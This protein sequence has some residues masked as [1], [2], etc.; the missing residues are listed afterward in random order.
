MPKKLYLTSRKFLTFTIED[1]ENNLDYDY[2]I[3]FH[4][5]YMIRDVKLKNF[6]FSKDKVIV[7]GLLFMGGRVSNANC[8]ERFHLETLSAKYQERISNI[9]LSKE[10]IRKINEVLILFAKELVKDYLD[11]SDGLL[12]YNL[13]I[14]SKN[15][16]TYLVRFKDYP[17]IIGS[18]KT[19]SLA[20]KEAE[21]NL[22]IYFEYKYNVK[23]NQL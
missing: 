12:E 19:K 7:D 1:K 15:D 18:G 4:G 20:V 11:L 17:F 9:I 16:E 6:S 10:I 3:F 2:V 8:D 23:L 22:K 5:D 21:E 14:N 13:S